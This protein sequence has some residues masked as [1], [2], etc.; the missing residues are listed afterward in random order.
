M[1]RCRSGF[2]SGCR[3]GSICRCRTYSVGTYTVGVDVGVG[4]LMGL[5]VGVVVGVGPTL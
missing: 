3:C 1:N 5:C 2:R 4:V